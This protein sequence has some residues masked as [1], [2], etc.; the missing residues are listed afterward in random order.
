M[1]HLDHLY[2]VALYLVKNEDEARD[3]V[4]ETCARALNSYRQFKPGSNMKAWLTRILYNFFFDNYHRAKRTVTFGS[5]KAAGEEN[6]DYLDD[7]AADD[8]GPENDL[9]RQ[10]L[11]VKIQDALRS[12]PD[13]FRTP[14]LLVDVGDFSYAEAAEILS[15]PVGTVRSRLSRG[16]KLMQRHL[17]GY[18]R[19]TQEG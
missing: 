7:L 5:Q 14:I 1:S 9:L 6:Q 17:Q 10:E 15:C 18:L 13:E 19:L 8:P 3:C 4:Q 11:S 16:R 12:L 2:R